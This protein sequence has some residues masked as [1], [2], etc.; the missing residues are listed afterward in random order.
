MGET[1]LGESFELGPGGKGSNQSVAAG[2]AGRA[3]CTFIS[4]LGADA[5]G[6]IACATW[7]EAGV[8]PAVAAD[9][10]RAT[11]APPIIFVDDGTGDNA[12]IVAPGAADDDRPGRR[13]RRRPTRSATPA[14]FVTQL[15][16]P[17]AAAA[18]GLEIARAAGVTTILNPAPG[19]PLGDD[20][21]AR[22]ATT[23]RR[24]RPRPR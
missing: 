2:A 11:P 16:Q 5:F 20:D 15:E 14:V 19:A 8:T 9:R 4:R 3:T 17:L 12:I 18:R 1:I 22:S 10:R 13:R 6:D 24:T 7:A 23:S 21:P